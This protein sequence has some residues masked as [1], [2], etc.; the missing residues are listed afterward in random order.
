[1]SQSHRQHGWTT[2]RPDDVGLHKVLFYVTFLFAALA[3]IL[4]PMTENINLT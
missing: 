4:P 3:A 2:G 1:M